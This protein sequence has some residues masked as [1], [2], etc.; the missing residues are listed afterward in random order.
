MGI[1]IVEERCKSGSSRFRVVFAVGCSG[2]VL[3]FTPMTVVFSGREVAL[4]PQELELVR[5]ATYATDVSVYLVRNTQ[6]EEVAVFADSVLR[7]G[8]D[9]SYFASG[10]LF[11]PIAMIG[12]C[13]LLPA[14]SGDTDVIFTSLT[15]D[16]E[17]DETSANAG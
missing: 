6:S 15:I 11:Q 1:S 13:T 9:R 5:H 14:S 4:E 7:D 3:R 10:S 16:E 2:A 12:R 17:S 8:V